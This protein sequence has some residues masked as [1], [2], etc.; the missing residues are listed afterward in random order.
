RSLQPWVTTNAVARAMVLYSAT[1]PADAS[2]AVVCDPAVAR[3]REN[4]ARALAAAFSHALGAIP[5]G[6]A[7]GKGEVGARTCTVDATSSVIGLL[8]AAP[9]VPGAQ[10]VARQHARTLLGAAAPDGRVHPEH[11]LRADGTGSEPI[12]CAGAWARGQAWALLGATEAVRVWGAPW[13][14]PARAIAANWTTLPVPPADVA[15]EPGPVDTSAAAIAADALRLL[16]A[17]DPERSAAHRAAAQNLCAELVRAHLTGSAPGLL[18]KSPRG[19]LA[20]A[21]YRTGP[22]GREQVECVWG[23]YHLLRALCDTDPE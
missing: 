22:R 10:N 23:G 6:T 4:G 19:V 15:G 1:D 3:L 18:P 20:H 5:D 7:L 12:G 17:A 16:A 8:C 21:C 2:D 13:L 11:R 14:A 9:K